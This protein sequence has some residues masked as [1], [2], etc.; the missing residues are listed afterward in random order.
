MQIHIFVKFQNE[1]MKHTY[2]PGKRVTA[3]PLKGTPVFYWP[4]PIKDGGGIRKPFVWIYILQ[5]YFKILMISHLI[6][7]FFF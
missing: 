7:A 2:I 1:I 6:S 3:P 4:R 5:K